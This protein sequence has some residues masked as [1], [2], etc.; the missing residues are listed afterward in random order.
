MKMTL[1]VILCQFKPSSQQINAY[2]NK[3]IKLAKEDRDDIEDNYF[4]IHKGAK[5]MPK[6]YSYY[7]YLLE[8]AGGS[9]EKV[10]NDLEKEAIQELK[11]TP[12][13]YALFGH[14]GYSI[15][16]SDYESVTNH[17]DPNLFTMP[18]NNL[19]PSEKKELYEFVPSI[20]KYKFNKTP[21]IK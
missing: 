11:T 17:K 7:S 2:V 1:I 15:S 18:Y 14:N 5:S 12:S 6:D 8:E 20:S 13:W 4:A 16:K 3:L 9:E 10:R 19:T 21:E